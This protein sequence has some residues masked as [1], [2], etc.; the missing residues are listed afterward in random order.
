MRAT[1]VTLSAPDGR[2]LAGTLRAPPSPRAA[3]LVAG[4]TG[5]PARAYMALAEALA[6]SGLAV[7]TFD[8]RGI[9]KSSRAPVRAEGA[10]MADWGRLDLEGALSWLAA[11]HEGLPL[12]LLGH[13]V[14]GQLLGLAP[15]AT[16]LR[17]AL[18]VGAQSGYW[19]NWEGAAQLRVWL[20]WHLLLPGL[21]TALGYGPMRALGMG[22]NLPAGV[23]QQW[24]RW[25]RHPEHLLSECSTGER[26]RY[27]RLGFPIRF[28]R[29][30]DD[31]F[32]PRRAVEQLV[33]FYRGAVTEVVTRSPADVSASAIG[34]FGWLKPPFRDTLWR[35]MADW[36]HSRADAVSSLGGETHVPRRLLEAPT[37]LDAEPAA[38][39]GIQQVWQDA[40]LRLR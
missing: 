34:H 6:W 36:L 1:E 12:L 40:S 27:G 39:R 3:V 10:T 33:G 23:A 9:A 38:R 26:E 17:G 28:Y 8:Y 32:A 13:S 30:T 29:F 25:G 21:S 20:S 35:E 7:L 2:S 15:T 14:G 37:P 31:E 5:V 11:H 22:E 19:R 24:A 4:A 18:L 16:A